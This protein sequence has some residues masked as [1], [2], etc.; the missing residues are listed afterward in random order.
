[1][2]LVLSN[3]AFADLTN[4]T[5]ADEDTK[6]MWQCKWCNL[7]ANFGTNASGDT[8]SPIFEPMHNVYCVQSNG[9]VVKNAL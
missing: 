1:M 5:L 8:W 2:G 6:A 3:R 4:V 7:V 9:P